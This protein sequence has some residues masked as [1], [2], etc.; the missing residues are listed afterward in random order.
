M[1]VIFEYH[2]VTASEALE[3]FTR[4]QLNKL[5][6]KYQFVHRA[7]VFFKLENTSSDQTGKISGVRLS[8]PGPRMFAESSSD[9]FHA[10]LKKAIS[11]VE[12]Q[13]RKKKEKMQSHH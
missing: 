10:S 13:L 11:E 9:D 4:E 12:Q 6:D 8:M 2:D 7:D 3:A 1:E 5:G